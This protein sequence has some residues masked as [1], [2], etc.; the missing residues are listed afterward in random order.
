MEKLKETVKARKIRPAA[1]SKA[2]VKPA[3]KFT[4]ELR[5]K[6]CFAFDFGEYATKIAVAKVS[7]GKISVKHL[8]VVENDEQNSK[9]D[10]SNIK[11]W[12]AKLLRVFNQS[13]ISVSGQAAVCT[14]GSRYYISR[15]LEIPYAE[16]VDLHGLVAYEMSN[17]LSLD[18]DSYY[19]QYKL[20]SVY[21]KNGGK[22]CSVWVAA[23][24]KAVCDSY[25]E[26][27]ESLRLKPL[28]MDININGLARLFAADGGLS[29]MAKDSV[30]ATVDLG[31]RS[32]EVNIFKNGV[33]VQ[34]ANVDIGDGKLVSAAK[35]VL[36][37]QIAD[38]RNGNKLIVKPR[39]IYDI[40][41]RTD[42]AGARAFVSVVEEWLTEIYGVVRR[43]NISY[44]A[45][46]VSKI[47]LYGGS[48]QQI[49]LK[50]YLEKYLGVPTELVQSLDCCNIPASLVQGSNTFPQCLNAI[51]LLL[52]D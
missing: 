44:P 10:S 22:V 33:Y 37:V 25:Y 24:Q 8:L 16:N 40:M 29:D 31:I 39:N 23:L 30:V 13:G 47:L 14:V 35:S 34:G 38:I 42:S 45:E 17:S 46:P 43:Y 12:R 26:L 51:S 1:K 27:L 49:W 52:M 15:R 41:R 28:V 2:R 32:T 36:G 11:D 6:M 7:K 50:P 18:M 3:K 4:D 19:F 21:E 48:P 20:L 5:G 9:I